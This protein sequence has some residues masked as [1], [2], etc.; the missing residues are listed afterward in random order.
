VFLYNTLLCNFGSSCGQFS[1]EMNANHCVQTLLA[2]QL[3]LKETLSP[4][5]SGLIWMISLQ[6]FSGISTTEAEG[7][8][9]PTQN[10]VLPC[11][12][13]GDGW[14]GDD[15]YC[16]GRGPCSPSHV[17]LYRHAQLLSCKLL[18]N[19]AAAA[20]AGTK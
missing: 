16:D 18:A 12:A 7:G 3:V 8:R 1:L 17:V 10:G 20:V 11:V 9:E 2:G 14:R 13:G 15:F 5:S 4:V 19:P 6:L